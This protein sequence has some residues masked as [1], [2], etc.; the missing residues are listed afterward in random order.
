MSTSGKNEV[1][2][3]MDTSSGN[4]NGL[5]NG[6]NRA[7]TPCPGSLVDLTNNSAMSDYAVSMKD[8]SRPPKAVLKIS[9]SSPPLHPH[10]QGGREG[11][12]Y[13]IEDIVNNTNIIPAALPSISQFPTLNGY[14]LIKSPS[15][16][17]FG[18]DVSEG[19]AAV[20]GGDRRPSNTTTIRPLMLPLSRTPTIQASSQAYTHI[21]S[22]RRP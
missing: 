17:D 22:R 9:P 20:A 11:I 5:R 4:N 12:G 7:L 18:A 2:A 8:D 21:S 1:T 3:S 14:P 13:T 19:D 15:T 16:M 10:N 6:K